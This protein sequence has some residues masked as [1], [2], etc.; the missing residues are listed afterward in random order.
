V[1]TIAVIA[2]LA[3]TFSTAGTM[4]TEDPIYQSAKQVCEAIAT[5]PQYENLK[6]VIYPNYEDFAGC[7]FFNSKDKKKTA[8]G[9]FITSAFSKKQADEWKKTHQELLQNGAIA[10]MGD[11]RLLIL[12]TKGMKYSIKVSEGLGFD[13]H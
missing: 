13:Q 2:A 8:I 9:V 3:T 7:T 5:Q 10:T 11:K 12:L 1:K 6:L 4:M